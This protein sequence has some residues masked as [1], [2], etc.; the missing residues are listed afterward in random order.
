THLPHPAQVL[1]LPGVQAGVFSDV[2]NFIYNSR[3]AVPS[4]AAA[5]ELGAV[6]RRLGISCLQGLEV[7]T[8]K[9]MNGSWTPPVTGDPRSPAAPVDL[10]CPP[11]S[12]DTSVHLLGGP[13]FQPLEARDTQPSANG[14]QLAGS[15]LRRDGQAGVVDEVED[16]GEDAGLDTGKLQNLGRGWA[17]GFFGQSLFEE[18]AG[19][20]QDVFMGSEFGVLGDDG[21][22]TELAPQPLLV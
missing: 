9:E 19:C 15:C 3:L 17:G 10:T 2:L 20:G 5:R 14:A 11:R 6:G 16:V 8:P 12:S 1:E 22:V 4:Q 21:D 18:G 13:H 7:G